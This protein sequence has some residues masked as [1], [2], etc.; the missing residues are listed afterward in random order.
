MKTK[1]VQI[2]MHSIQHDVSEEVEENRYTGTYALVGNTHVIHY[3]EYLETQDGI[4][5]QKN[6]NLLK[7]TPTAMKLNKKGA[8][9]TRMHFQTGTQHQDY[10]ETPFGTFD[11]T[12]KTQN[13]EMEQTDD[14]LSVTICYH[15]HLNYA[16]VSKCTMRIEIIL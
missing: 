5:P 7:I 12:I 15:L 2:I 9:T 14:K 1:E 16:S 3:D 11:L 4:A 8:I 6:T 10:Y 13:F